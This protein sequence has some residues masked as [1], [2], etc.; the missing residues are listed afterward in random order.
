MTKKQKDTIDFEHSLAEL[1]SIIEKMEKGELTL[2]Q[3]LQDFER[4]V[5]LTRSCQKA[6]KDAEQRVMVLMS[7][8]GEDTLQTLTPPPGN[9]TMES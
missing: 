9:E 5:F 6:L 7:Q 4:G 2:E 8:A 1:E 3:S